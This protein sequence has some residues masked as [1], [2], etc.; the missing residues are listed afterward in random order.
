ML[1]ARGPL[2]FLFPVALLVLTGCGNGDRPPLGRVSGKVTLD[3][4]PAKG[5][6]I[7]FSP[8]NGR[9][10]AATTDNNGNYTLE[11]SHGVAG[12]KVGKCRVSFEWPTAQPGAPIAPKYG[13]KS[14]LV[15]DVQPK[16]NVLNYD[17]TSDQSKK[18]VKP[19]D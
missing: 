10:A 11:Y 14:E 6:I 19:V 15:A 9:P 2:H 3:G 16:S 7:M 5:L 12:A 8:E 13:T 4:Q 1:A 17:I 18:P